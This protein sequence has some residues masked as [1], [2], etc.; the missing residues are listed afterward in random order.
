MHSS[1]QPKT[2]KTQEYIAT[3]LYWVCFNAPFVILFTQF[4]DW[5][6]TRAIGA[7]L[8]FIA[9]LCTPDVVRPKFW[10]SMAHFT[11][12]IAFFL[13]WGYLNILAGVKA[14]DDPQSLIMLPTICLII[15][16]SLAARYIVKRF[17]GTEPLAPFSFSRRSEKSDSIK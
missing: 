10:V 12:G 4:S 7:G 5:E 11:I 9:L 3:V 13:G 8:F 6:I 16:L 14:L 15:G 1:G 17:Y 2:Q